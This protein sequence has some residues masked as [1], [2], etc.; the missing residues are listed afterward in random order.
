MER[1]YHRW[2]SPALGRDME[3]LVFGH[4]GDQWLTFPTSQGRF[5]DWEDNGMIAALSPWLEAGRAQLICVDSIDGESW[6]AAGRPPG[7]RAARHAAYDRYLEEEVLPLL[8]WLVPGATIGALGCSFGAYH[9]ANFALRRPEAVP[10]AIALSGLYDIAH[11]GAVDE[12]PGWPPD[13]YTDENVAAHDPADYI[14]NP[15]HEARVEAWR[16]MDLW[17]SSGCGDAGAA[18]LRRFSEVLGRRD[19]PHSVTWVRGVAHDW[20][21]WRELLVRRFAR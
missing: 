21:S 19:I 1:L 3:L 14:A 11:L 12:E 7:E 18:D 4:A 15:G 13:G 6:Y 16:R 5:Y 10:R 17:L 8:W 20:P 9:A 2:Y